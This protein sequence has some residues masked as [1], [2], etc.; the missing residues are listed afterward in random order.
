MN[1]KHHWGLKPQ[2]LYLGINVRFNFILWQQTIRSIFMY[3][4]LCCKIESRIKNQCFWVF[5]ICPKYFPHA[6]IESVIDYLL[7]LVNNA[8]AHT[9]VCLWHFVSITYSS[10]VVVVAVV[11]LLLHTSHWHDKSIGIGSNRRVDCHWF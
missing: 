6:R 9:N 4:S 11:L 7:Y 8:F 5:T 1:V 3:C 2:V 10:Y